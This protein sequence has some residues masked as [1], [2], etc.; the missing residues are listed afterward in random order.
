[1]AAETNAS[2]AKTEK[3]ERDLQTLRIGLNSGVLA[4]DQK[5]QSVTIE[6]IH[7]PLPI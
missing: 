6:Y 2:N 7:I 4:L 3:L 1:M 5:L